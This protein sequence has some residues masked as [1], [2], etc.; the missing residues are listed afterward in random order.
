[1]TAMNTSIT[2]IASLTDALS[3]RITA[4]ATNATTDSRLIISV[5]KAGATIL[6]PIV[7]QE[8]AKHVERIPTYRIGPIQSAT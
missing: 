4:P 8:Y 1:M 2:P 5:A 7:W 3:C 6:W